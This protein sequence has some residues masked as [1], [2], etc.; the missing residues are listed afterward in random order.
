[1]MTMRGVADDASLLE[2]PAR[3]AVVRIC[4][5]PD[6]TWF[7]VGVDALGRECR[8]ILAQP[9]AG[10]EVT[11]QRAVEGR[12]DAPALAVEDGR[13]R[14]R[15]GEPQR[16]ARTPLHQGRVQPRTLGDPPHD[17]GDRVAAEV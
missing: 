6:L 17:V 1:M 16:R 3:R 9:G 15:G 5:I 13:A 14:P 2:A 4:S 8:G 7:W 10:A 11:I 12:H